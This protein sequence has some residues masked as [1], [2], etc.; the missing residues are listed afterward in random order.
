[1]RPSILFIVTGDPRT[2]ARPAEAIRIAAGIGS[3]QRTDVHLY[4]HGLAVQALS[5]FADELP[6]GDHY[7]RYLPLIAGLGRPIYVDAGA[8]MPVAL[9]EIAVPIQKIDNP[10][11]AALCTRMTYVSRF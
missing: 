2:S 11:L 10:E 4:L 9:E 1:M 3:W 6:D 7:V 5:P 8:S